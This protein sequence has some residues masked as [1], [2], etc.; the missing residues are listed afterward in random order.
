MD[1]FHFSFVRYIQQK[2][3]SSVFVLCPG[4]SRCFSPSLSP[5]NRRRW[6]ARS[7]PADPAGR[8]APARSGRSWTSSGWMEAASRSERGL[9]P[10]RWDTQT[11]RRSEHR[12]YFLIIRKIQTQLF[13]MQKYK[14]NKV[15]EC[16]G[17]SEQ[18]TEHSNTLIC[19][20]INSMQRRESQM[21]T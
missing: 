18:T 1:V 16:E 7:P 15:N 19:M 2:I 17:R 21:E 9:T 14:W 3:L 13:Y 6:C 5:Q 12:L 4:S 11:D 20:Y 10:P 8:T